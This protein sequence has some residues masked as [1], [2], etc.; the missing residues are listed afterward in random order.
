MNNI[1]ITIFSDNIG[2]CLHK[3]E[4]EDFSNEY[5]NV[6]LSF[7]TTNNIC[8]DR[9]IIIDYK[10]KFERIYHCGAS[11]KDAGKRITTI[12][13]VQDKGMYYFMIDSLLK[14]KELALK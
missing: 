9:Y 2:N 5:P 4:Y 14:N 8:H 7:K 10:S 3:F 12:T 13:E 6:H 1:K 11:S